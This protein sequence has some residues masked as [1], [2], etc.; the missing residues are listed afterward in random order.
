MVTRDTYF[1]Q[2]IRKYDADNGGIEA[3]YKE[4]CRH[5]EEVEAAKHA[6]EDAMKSKEERRSYT[7]CL[8]RANQ[9]TDEMIQLLK[10]AGHNLETEDWKADWEEMIRQVEE[11]EKDREKKRKEKIREMNKIKET[12]AN[13]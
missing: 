2:I 5:L 9:I 4:V 13:N 7:E 11:W 12:N 1:M 10:D 8:E 6:L 3:A